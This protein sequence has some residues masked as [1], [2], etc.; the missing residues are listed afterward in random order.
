MSGGGG[1]YQ[2]PQDN[3]IQLAQLQFQ[4]QQE[5][6]Q[7][8]DAAQALKDQQFQTNLSTAATG[9][10]GTG[11]SILAQ[12]GLDPTTYDPVIQQ[13]ITDEQAKVPIDDPN[14]AQY[15]TSDLINSALTD[16]Q[17]NTQS[18]NN[19]AVNNTFA[20]GFETTALPDS[21]TSDYVN[22]ILT[23]QQGQA[24]D[25]L[26]AA[27]QRGQLND[28][29]LAAA[30]TALGTQ[31]SAATSTLDSLANSVLNTDRSGLD[32]IKSTAAN[33]ANSWQLGDPNFSIDPYQT[34]ESNAVSKDTSNFGG[35]LTNALGSTPLFNVNS[36]LLN[37]SAAQGPQNLTTASVP[38]LPVKK[39]N[40]D[41]GLGSSGN[42]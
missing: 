16:D 20:P 33:D 25:A 15:F 13:A 2:A 35:D 8:A 32:N 26:K 29:G 22:Q 42:F 28:T 6:Q 24:Q 10:M 21:L 40:T 39:N 9:A 34:Q 7:E 41:R 38:G 31:S 3:S 19:T 4:Q 36:I 14:P 5:Q 37:G 17:T 12:R 23:T 11:N 27:Q 1:G 18:R 30:D